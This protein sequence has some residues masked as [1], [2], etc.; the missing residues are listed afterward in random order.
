MATTSS[1]LGGLFA[2]GQGHKIAQGYGMFLWAG[3]VLFVATAWRVR[4]ESRPGSADAPAAAVGPA[5]RPGSQPQ[6]ARSRPG[7]VAG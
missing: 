5:P 7:V 2:H 6:F 4:V 3:I 1:E